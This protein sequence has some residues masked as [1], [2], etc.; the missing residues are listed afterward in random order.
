MHRDRKI[1]GF[2]VGVFCTPYCLLTPLFEKSFAFIYF[3]VPLNL[4][5]FLWREN[6]TSD[7]CSQ[8]SLKKFNEFPGICLQPT[9]GKSQTA[10]SHII[11]T[12]TVHLDGRLVSSDS[13]LFQVAE[14]NCG[15]EI[16]GFTSTGAFC[17]REN[18]QETLLAVPHR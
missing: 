2:E 18:L 10:A 3:R 1:D 11:S 5:Q 4:S 12:S 14:V 6:L 9:P 8:F 7:V 13:Q 16:A 15:E 17:V